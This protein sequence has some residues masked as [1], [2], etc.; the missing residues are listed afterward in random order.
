VRKSLKFITVQIAEYDPTGDRMIASAL[1]KELK[2]YGWDKSASTTPA[3]YLVG[4]LAAKKALASGVEKAVLDIGLNT[5]SKGAK[6]FAALKGMVDAG[7]EIPHNPEVMPKDDRVK[8]THLGGDVV[9]KFESVKSKLEALE[10][11]PRTK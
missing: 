11:K 2:E 1:S 4:Y 7:L 10:W 8:G 6:V 5:P 3:A 9:K